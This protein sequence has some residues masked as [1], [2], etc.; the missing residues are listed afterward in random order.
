MAV[1]SSTN[2]SVQDEADMDMVLQSEILFIDKFRL[3]ACTVVGTEAIQITVWITARM[4]SCF[5]VVN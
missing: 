2:L 4:G 5:S 3:V 1:N